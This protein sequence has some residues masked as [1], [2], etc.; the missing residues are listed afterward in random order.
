[1][2]HHVVCMA[3]SI[4]AP[5][6]KPVLCRESSHNVLVGLLQ[7]ALSREAPRMSK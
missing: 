5:C 7:V 1:M 4:L 3:A 6:V 2:T